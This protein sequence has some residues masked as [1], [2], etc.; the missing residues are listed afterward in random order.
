MMPTKVKILV[1]LIVAAILAWAI[2]PRHRL[3]AACN[4]KACDDS[5]CYTFDQYCAKEFG[6]WVG[7]LW[8]KKVV[9]TNGTTQYWCTNQTVEGGSPDAPE[10]IIYKQ[11]K[12]C[13]PHCAGDGLTTGEASGDENW[14]AT[15]TAVRTKCKS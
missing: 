1:A 2:T 8:P 10:E 11:V 12:S 6:V 7:Y 14:S 3:S 5:S 4:S 13:K 15:D 9:Q